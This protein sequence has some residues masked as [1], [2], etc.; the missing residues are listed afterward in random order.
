MSGHKTRFTCAAGRMNENLYFLDTF[1]GNVML[2]SSADLSTTNFENKLVLLHV[3]SSNSY[4]SNNLKIW[5]N[6]LVMLQFL[7]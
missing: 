1:G 7:L 3:I 5:Y 2:N 6:R 4:D